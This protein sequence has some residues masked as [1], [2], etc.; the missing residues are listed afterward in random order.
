MVMK[1]LLIL[2][3]WVVIISGCDRY[4]CVHHD[5]NLYLVFQNN[6]SYDITISRTDLSTYSWIKELPENIEIPA[7][8]SY[9][10]KVL[11]DYLCKVFGKVTFGDNLVVDYSDYPDNS[12]NITKVKNYAHSAKDSYWHFYTYTFTDAD[13]QYALENGQKLE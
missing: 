3:S 4:A 7:K 11:S 12:Y 6:S 13:Y 1:R 8:E 9:E 10:L 2:V 5:M